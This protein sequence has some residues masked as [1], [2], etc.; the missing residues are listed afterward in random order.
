MEKKYHIEMQDHFLRKWEETWPIFLDE[1]TNKII[2]NIVEILQGE[3]KQNNLISEVAPK[4]H[5]TSS[6]ISNLPNSQ[7]QKF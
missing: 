3:N 2:K 6:L 5:T 7:L 1:N 4:I